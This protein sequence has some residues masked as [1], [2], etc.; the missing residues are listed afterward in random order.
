MA[1]PSAPPTATEIKSSANKEGKS[2]RNRHYCYYHLHE[3][4]YKIIKK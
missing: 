2:S 4:E 1:Q 3:I